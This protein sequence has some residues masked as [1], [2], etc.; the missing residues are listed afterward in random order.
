MVNLCLEFGYMA[1]WCAQNPPRRQQFHVAP[2]MPVD[3]K[4]KKKEERNALYK[5][6][7]SCGITCER[8]ESARERRI[9]QHKSNRQQLA[10]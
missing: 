10:L 4:N 1:V 2:A 9:A 8:S 6:S 5:V 7:H 3:I